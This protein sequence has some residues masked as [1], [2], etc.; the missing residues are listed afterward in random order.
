MYHDKYGYK[1]I[2]TELHM[3]NGLKGRIQFIKMIN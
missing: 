2:A 1:S 3:F